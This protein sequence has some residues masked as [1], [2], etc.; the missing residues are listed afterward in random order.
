MTE[1]SKMTGSPRYWFPA[2][3][4]GWGWSAPRCW[5]GW[6]VVLLILAVTA[7]GVLWLARTQAHRALIPLLVIG[8]ST[9]LVIVCLIKGEPTRWRWGDKD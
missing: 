2:K 7:I 8:M 6:L 5:Q 1:E 9:I 3:R 4:Y